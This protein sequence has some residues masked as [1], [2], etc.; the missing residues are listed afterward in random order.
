MSESE[1]FIHS[2][3]NVHSKAQLEAGVSIGPY[4]YIGEKV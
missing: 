2:T 1:V 3:A 4:T